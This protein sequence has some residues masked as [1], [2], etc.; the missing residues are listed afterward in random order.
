MKRVVRVVI[1][2]IGIFLF[3]IPWYLLPYFPII[4]RAEAAASTVTSSAD[5]QAGEFNGVEA[6]SKEGEIKL[7]PA[8]T[9]GPRV[10][11]TPHLAQTDQS[12]LASDGTYI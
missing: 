9:W 11:H 3:G 2:Y 10:F 7:N 12:A 4:P 6:T 1:A 5:F 8:G